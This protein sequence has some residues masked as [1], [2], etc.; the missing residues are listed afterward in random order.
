MFDYKQRPRS[1]GI[2]QPEWDRILS[3]TATGPIPVVF[4]RKISR[5]VAIK[6]VDYPTTHNAPESVA[7]T[8]SGDGSERPADS[9]VC[10]ACGCETVRFFSFNNA[11][12]CINLHCGRVR[13][14]SRVFPAT[15]YTIE[16]AEGCD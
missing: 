15:N 2:S 12:I 5:P 10:T 13:S 14:E 16:F 8:H 4:G 1:R 9:F 6:A 3:N 11:R 7:A